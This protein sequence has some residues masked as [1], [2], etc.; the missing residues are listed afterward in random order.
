MDILAYLIPA[1]LATGAGTPT[2][3]AERERRAG[4]PV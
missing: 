1:A 4:T 3:V 2:D